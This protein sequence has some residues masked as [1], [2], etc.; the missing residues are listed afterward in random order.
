MKYSFTLIIA[1]LITGLGTAQIVEVGPGFT[2]LRCQNGNVYSSGSNTDG[3][4]G[5]GTKDSA[6]Y[7]TQIQIDSVSQISTHGGHVIAVMNNGNVSGWGQN[8]VGQLGDSSFQNIP[9][10][11]NIPF[12]A[13]IIQVEAGKYHSLFLDSNGQ[14]HGLGSNLFGKLGTLRPPYSHLAPVLI[15]GIDSVIKISAGD[16]HSLAIRNDSTV[17]SWGYNSWGQLG[18]GNTL[19]TSKPRQVMILSRVID[20]DA[21]ISESYAVTFDGRVYGWGKN[22]QGELGNAVARDNNPHPNPVVIPGISN[23]VQ[24]EAGYRYALAL[25]KDGTVMAWGRNEFYELGDSTTTNRYT[26]VKV[27][28]L[29]HIHSISANVGVAFAIDSSGQIFSWGYSPLGSLA[30][31]MDTLKPVPTPVN[32]TD[33]NPLVSVPEVSRRTIQEPE[34]YPNP[35][36]GKIHW[37]SNIPIAEAVLLD[38]TGQPVKRFYK[39]SALDITEVPEG[40]YLLKVKTGNEWVVRKIWKR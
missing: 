39:P 7:F 2:M 37:K 34:F 8:D 24:V 5:L 11:V 35:T 13:K 20:I 3:A 10:P 16:N 30:S 25:L 17:W 40:M 22:S 31:G 21:G 1:I 32:F 38:L 4:L 12:N 29:R 14:I 26:P 33:C 9:S 36:T 27:K 28:N 23:A 19:D 6:F 15:P 18:H